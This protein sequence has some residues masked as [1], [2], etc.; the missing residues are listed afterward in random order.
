[1]TAT[2][3]VVDG[4][5]GV[6]AGG[7]VMV[8]WSPPITTVLPSDRTVVC[9]ADGMLVGTAAPVWGI[10]ALGSCIAVG[11]AELLDRDVAV[12]TMAA[13]DWERDWK[14]VRATLAPMRIAP[15]PMAPPTAQ[16]AF[17]FVRM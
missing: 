3:G 4:L 15:M 11:A 8:D 2:S 10:G 6:G 5:T 14:V 16:T 13:S 1:M 12:M 9:T 17:E 7:S